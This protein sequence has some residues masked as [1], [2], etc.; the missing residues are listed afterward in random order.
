[1]ASDEG[2][3]AVYLTNWR[4]SEAKIVLKQMI[5]DG[6]VTEAH[7]PPA[8]YKMNDIFKGYDPKK[9]KTN[10]NNLRK[11]MQKRDSTN[12]SSSTTAANLNQAPTEVEGSVYLKDWRSSKTKQ[13][14]MRLI[15]DG[16]VTAS[17][18]AKEV[19]AMYDG[20]KSYKFENF[21][22]NLQNLLKSVTDDAEFGKFDQSALEHDRLIQGPE[23]ENSILGYPRWYGTK[24]QKHL[25]EVVAS[26]MH[27]HLDLDEILEMNLMW[28]NYPLEV[29]QRHIRQEENR[30]RQRSYWLEKMRKKN[31]KKEEIDGLLQ[32]LNLDS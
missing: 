12:A 13:V 25:Q 5:Q 29:F 10:L 17:N 11:S 14:L 23:P 24:H 28:G 20:F 18:T 8:V 26:G 9:F 19:Y 21:Q 31:A 1:M 32:Q 7:A 15:E 4:T 22:T 16:K 3:P 2:N 6:Q 30:H 27:E